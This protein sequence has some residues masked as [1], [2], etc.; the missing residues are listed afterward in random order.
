VTPLVRATAGSMAALLCACAPP[1]DAPAPL[2]FGVLDAACTS[3]RIAAERA[4]GVTMVELP[5]AWDRYQPERGEV[6][7]AYVAELHRKIDTCKAAGMRITLGL[8][9]QYPPAWVRALPNAVMRGSAGH[10][11]AHGGLDLVF[12]AA[13]RDAANGYIARLAT[14]L[15]LASAVSGVTAVRVGVSGTGEL[16]YPGPDAAHAPVVTPAEPGS[17]GEDPDVVGRS[18]HEWWAFGP[19]PQTGSGLAIGASVSPLPGWVPGQR[20][21]QGAAVTPEQADAWLRWYTTSLIDTVAW[22]IGRL[23]ELGFTG[24]VHVPVAGR[25]ILP[26]D[27]AAA[28]DGL[29]DGR[30]DPDGALERGLDYPSQFPILAGLP[31]VVVD[32]TGLDDVTAVNARAQGYDRCEPDDSGVGP[33]GVDLLDRDDTADWPGQRFTSALARRLGLRLVGENPGSPDAPHTG[34]DPASD[35]SAQQMRR[36]PDYARECGM[37]EFY[38]AFENDLFTP[39]SGVDLAAYAARIAGGAA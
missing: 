2:A 31:G 24:D 39:G 15:S 21:W 29:L 35:S 17:A 18:A 34:G 13:V 7:T 6:D 11:P 37:T 8:G 26:L 4:A 30:A 28:V 3:D 12:N 33:D 19:A 1:A 25:G 16:A 23:R 27:R 14:D 10:T 32:F 9:L 20:E 36:A 38:W 5:L 22:Q